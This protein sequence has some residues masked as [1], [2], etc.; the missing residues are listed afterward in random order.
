MPS[1]LLDFD[2]QLCL[3]NLCDVHE[4][5]FLTLDT[6]H[7]GIWKKKKFASLPLLFSS[8][9]KFTVGDRLQCKLV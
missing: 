3:S 5:G 2:C 8:R 7:C 1:F 9:T 4:N 6:G